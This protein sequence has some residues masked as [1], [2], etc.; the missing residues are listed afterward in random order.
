MKQKPEP[1]RLRE[2]ILP[3]RKM[4]IGNDV[5]WVPKNV[6]RSSNG[7]AACWYFRVQKNNELIINKMFYDGNATPA[8][9]LSRLIDFIKTE[10]E[11][12]VEKQGQRSIPRANKQIDTGME[13]VCLSWVRKNYRNDRYEYA[14]VMTVSFQPKPRNYKTK[15]VRVGNIN[16]VTQQK[17]DR[18]MRI[19]RA[20][21]F[22]HNLLKAS[23]DYRS[24]WPTDE[25]LLKQIKNKRF[26]K[27]R[28][29]EVLAFY[30][31]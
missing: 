11:A 8:D 5:L 19:G 24:D 7:N 29:D 6:T 31:E 25:F 20:Y 15:S 18:A 26:P 10:A 1:L 9:S 13:G 21:R 4:V 27:I 30:P 12:I 23:G 14:L 2:K 17:L 3:Y 28:L 16:T 22:H